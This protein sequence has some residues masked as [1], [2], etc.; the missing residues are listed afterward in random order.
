MRRVYT[1]CDF[2][3]R[4]IDNNGDLVELGNPERIGAPASWECT[5]EICR[6]C[7]H[8]LSSALSAAKHSNSKTVKIISGTCGGEGEPAV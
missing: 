2:C 1:F 7:L 3:K 8:S 5:V 4:A 6:S